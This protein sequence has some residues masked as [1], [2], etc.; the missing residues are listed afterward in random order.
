MK[1]L[2]IYINNKVLIKVAPLQ[3]A[4]LLTK[5]IAGILVS[6]AMAVFIGPVGLALVGNLRNFVSSFQTISTLGFYNGIVKYVF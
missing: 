2:I 3:S 1:K 4:S 6:K 5:I